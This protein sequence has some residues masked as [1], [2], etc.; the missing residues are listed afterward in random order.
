[1]IH[2]LATCSACTSVSR[3]LRCMSQF[4][5]LLCMTEERDRDPESLV[6][7]LQQSASKEGNEPANNNID[8]D[9]DKDNDNDDENYI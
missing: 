3:I 5:A 6:S 4:F 8:N 9:N 1:M 7:T 2:A